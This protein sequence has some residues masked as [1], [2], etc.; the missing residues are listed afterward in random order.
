[1]LAGGFRNKRR[2][3]VNRWLIDLGILGRSSKRCGTTSFCLEGCDSIYQFL[4]QGEQI[5]CRLD[6]NARK[7]NVFPRDVVVLERLK[8]PAGRVFVGQ[9]L[10][11][12]GVN[13]VEIPRAN[14]P[15]QDRDVRVVRRTRVKPFG[16][17]F[18]RRP[19]TASACSIIVLSGSSAI[20]MAMIGLSF[21]PEF[22]A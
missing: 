9:D 4:L 12:D 2:N 10:V 3:V 17:T 11:D 1:M 15:L 14:V 13:F 8:F 5:V 21:A 6:H 7:A 16:K 19:L 18:N 20:S 22:S